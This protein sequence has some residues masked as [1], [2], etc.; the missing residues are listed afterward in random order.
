MITRTWIA[1]LLAAAAFAAE[2]P[3]V[4]LADLAREALG[5]NP[6]ILGAQK[7]Y[8]AARQRPTQ[9]ASLPDPMV[10]LGYASAGSPRPFAGIGREPTANAGVMVSQEIPFPGKLRLKGEMAQREA[11]AEFQQYQAV[12]LA[13][14]SRVKQA[15]YRLW[16]TWAASDVLARNRGVLERLL[17]VTE[18]RYG[19]GKAQ[20]QDVLRAQTQLSILETRLVKL[21]QERRSREAELVA[22]LARPSGAPLGR[23][24]EVRP[25][26]L[27]VTLEELLS[28]ARA[29]SP[30]LRRE[31]KMIERS[32]LAML[33]ARK[34]YY[35]DYALS[36]GYYNMGSMP[37][38][39]EFRADFK[40]P[41]YFWRKQRAGVAEQAGN[42]AQ[43]RRAYEAAGQNLEYRIRD[44][45][46]MAQAGQRL[47]DL[48]RRTVVPQA[49]LTLESSL[50]AYETG[51]ADFL[52]VLT[53]FTVILD[54]EM[55]YYDE[56]LGYSLALARLEEMT[57][58]PLAS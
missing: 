6:E 3:A 36:A 35:P 24:E 16:Y 25:A 15:Y 41:V 4:R 34:E 14:L 31:Q 22:L 20:Q 43:A 50:A 27:A 47:M 7:R 44:D 38:M 46:A 54:Y 51:A 55:N 39:Y 17:K 9:E 28:A 8:E 21:E 58:T 42:A 37:A 40:V 33:A 56:L 30:M 57:A 18:I 48:Y 10:S 52:S 23:P 53:N 29:N 13:V 2:P 19:V 5:R 11:E 49:G 12:S 1:A 32:D 45:Y 26:P